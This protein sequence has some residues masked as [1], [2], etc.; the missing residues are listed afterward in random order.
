MSNVKESGDENTEEIL[1]RGIR[2]GSSPALPRSA[3][4]ITAVI[5]LLGLAGWVFAVPLLK[6][7]LPGAVEMKSNAAVGLVLAA[8]ALFIL[9]DRPSPPAQRLAQR[10]TLVVAALGLVTL[11]EYAFGW[12]LGIDE[13]LFRDT[14]DAYNPYRGRMSP[15]SSVAFVLIGLALAAL[16][17]PALRRLASPAALFVMGIGA[18]AYVGYLWNANELVTDVWVPP[19]AINTAFAFILLGAGTFLA[20]QTTAPRRT[21]GEV[22]VGGSVETR[23]LAGFIGALVLLF[24]ASGYT[25]RTGA[26]F[27]ESARLVAYTQQVRSELNRL[28]ASISTAESTQR[29]YLLT[30]EPKIKEKYTL[31]A[32]QVVEY[33]QNLSQLVADNPEQMQ[34]LAALRPLIVQRMNALARHVSLFE[35]HGTRAAQAAMALDDGI[36]AMEAINGLFDRMDAVEVALLFKREVDFARTRE[37][38][39]VALL[40]M[41]ALATAM[42]MLLYRDIRRG[43]AARAQIRQALKLE[44]ERL[45]LALRSAGMAMWNSELRTDRVSLDER[46]AMIIGGEPGPRVTTAGDL[47]KLVPA[48]HRD[49]LLAAAAD[50][51][52]GRTD[53]YRVEHQVRTGSGEWRWIESQGEV[54]DRDA[55]GRALRMIGLNHDITER[56]QAEQDLVAA[57]DEAQRA[58]AA[59]DTFLATM[60]HEIRT[61]L[62]GL[63]GMLELLGLSRLDGEQRDSLQMARDSGR[64]LVRII[65]DVLDHAKMEAGKLELRLEPVSIAQLLRRVL[66]TYHAVASAKDLSL[67]QSVDP[68]ISPSLMAD[69]L[70]VSQILNNFV[71]NALKFTTEGYVE[72]RAELLGRSGGADTVCLSVTDTGIGIE[73]E[74]QQRLFQPF[75]QAGAV[76]ARL[77][78]GTG[79]GLSISRRLAEMMGGTIAVTSAP[80]D[81]TTMSVTF[82]LPISAAALAEPAREGSTAVAPILAAGAPGAGPLVLAVD[83]HPTNRG[84]LARQIAALGLRVQTAVDGREALTLWRA[85]GITLVV[86]D[87]NMP[88]MDGYAF[89]RAIREIE[90]KDGRPRTPVI[91]WTANVLPGAAAQCHAA[92][93]DDI[94]TKPAE[95]AVLK[96]MLS[97]WLPSA[98]TAMAGPDDAADAGSG[99]AQMAPIDLAELDKIAASAAERAEILLDFMTQSR[100]DLARLPSALTLQDLPACARIAHRM[101]GSSRMVGARELA[102]TCE[103]MERAARQGSP[104]DAGT[105]QAAMNRA[106]EQFRAHV[107]ETTGAN[108]EK[109]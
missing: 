23:I 20:N 4:A 14:T 92:G 19:V 24:V 44:T 21:A 105:A 12:Q 96:A 61:P 83:D 100:I 89:S 76:T 16:P 8:C 32:A 57:R 51:T 107:A 62:N 71:S 15:Y 29:N 25:Y 10:F 109:K 104:E 42:L 85:G 27:A 49:R 64:G 90:A 52:S 69:P 46:W 7:V 28:D 63:L 35:S 31:H 70:R 88:Q 17:H 54:V 30:G 41:L 79:L 91:A 97:K 72:V 1:G 39:L 99:A 58:N 60:S 6:S 80:G 84:L 37:L 102:A 48:Q 2:S 81:G 67:T 95:L 77:Y 73:P 34:T 11:V 82:T 9:C 53:K 94:L 66:N 106:L 56:K 38:S 33:E 36:P 45:D 3:A 103:T 86:T 74:A 75:E 78:G 13:L 26:E 18:V 22:I 5:G 40:V 47:L 55:Q 65:D 93:M 98:A 101:K 108:E 87:C 50:I 68:R 43:I 59:K